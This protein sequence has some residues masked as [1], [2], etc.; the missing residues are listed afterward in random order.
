M[1]MHDIQYFFAV[2]RQR[3]MQR[4]IFMARWDGIKKKYQRS[5]Q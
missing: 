4:F 2:E 5:L 3:T 1:A